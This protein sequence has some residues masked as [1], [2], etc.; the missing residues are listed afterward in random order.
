[1]SK[2]LEME[3]TLEHP[4]VPNGIT[5]VFIRETVGAGGRGSKAEKAIWQQKQ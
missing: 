3:I 1:M 5:M 4:A 2:D